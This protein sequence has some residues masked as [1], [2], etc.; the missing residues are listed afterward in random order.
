VK[1]CTYPLADPVGKGERK[2]VS[3]P[4][5]QKAQ[6]YLCNLIHIRLAWRQ[7]RLTGTTSIAS[8]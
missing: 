7:A 5:K 3:R 8:R 1:L 6:N 4:E 2:P